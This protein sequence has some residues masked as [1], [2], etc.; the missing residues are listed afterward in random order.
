MLND[1]IGNI[2][3]NRKNNNKYETRSR[4]VCVQ[5]RMGTAFH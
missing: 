2:K 4:V 3:V 1:L 5:R